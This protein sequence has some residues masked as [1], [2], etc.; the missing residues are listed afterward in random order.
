LTHCLFEFN[1]ASADYGGLAID[2]AKTVI[3]REC[4]IYNNSASAQYGGC[5]LSG[6]TTFVL[7]DVHIYDNIAESNSVGRFHI[8]YPFDFDDFNLTINKSRG[9]LGFGGTGRLILH[10]WHF[11][12]QILLSSTTTSLFYIYRSSVAIFNCTFDSV[13]SSYHTAVLRVENN[14]N[15]EVVISNCTFENVTCPGDWTVFCVLQPYLF[16]ITNCRFS[17]GTARYGAVFYCRT[18]NQLLLT[19]CLF[20]GNYDTYGHLLF[21]IENPALSQIEK[22][23][24][25]SNGRNGTNMGLMMI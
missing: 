7:E 5:F 18:P 14:M 6:D 22:C 21:Y 25:V 24:F 11:G 15:G 9:I 4:N 19:E 2:A 13:R 12:P 10:G 16:S 23:R 1:R 17:N 3:L 8:P 20:E